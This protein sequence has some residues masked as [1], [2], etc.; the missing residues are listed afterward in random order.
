MVNKQQ[1][2]KEAGQGKTQQLMKLCERREEQTMNNIQR[3][4][5]QQPH[6]LKKLPDKNIQAITHDTIQCFCTLH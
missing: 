2:F 6:C 3:Y 5:Q 1:D 4:Q